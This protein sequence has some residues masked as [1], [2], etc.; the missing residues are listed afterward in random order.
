MLTH[1]IERTRWRSCHV[2]YQQ[3]RA[4]TAALR[5]L[6]KADATASQNIPVWGA[7]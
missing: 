5:K 6:R 1:H 3:F 4:Q 2:R 7:A